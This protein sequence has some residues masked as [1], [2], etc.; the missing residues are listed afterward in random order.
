MLTSVGICFAPACE[1]GWHHRHHRSYHHHL[2]DDQKWW[3]LQEENYATAA[4]Q[5]KTQTRLSGGLQWLA[6]SPHSSF[7]FLG[8]DGKED[9]HRDLYLSPALLLSLL[10]QMSSTHTLMVPMTCTYLCHDRCSGFKEGVSADDLHR[11]DAHCSFYGLN[12][13]L[14]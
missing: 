6:P 1:G 5:Q 10:R 7:R 13:G 4:D 9:L 3:R 14:T 8:D 2:S 12:T 11:T